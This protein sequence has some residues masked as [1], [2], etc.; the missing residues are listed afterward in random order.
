MAMD[1]TPQDQPVVAASVDTLEARGLV[2]VASYRPELEYLFRHWLV[3]DAAYGSLLRQERRALHRLVGEALES[4]YPDRRGEQAGILAMHFEQAG[5]TERAIEYLVL[6]GRYG[7]QRAAIREAYAAFDRAAALLPPESPDEPD[8]L[9]RRRV[10]IAV[11]RARASWPFRSGAEVKAE[12]EAIEPVAERLGDAEL[13][14]Q[15]HVHLAMVHIELGAR[16]DDPAMARSLERLEQLSADLGDPSLAALPLALAGMSKVFSGPIEEGVRALEVA[17][18]RMERRHDSIGAA[19]SRGWLAIGLA[20]LGEF[21]AAEAAARQ[22]S[23]MAA[24]GDLIAQLDAQISEAMVRSLRGDLDRAAPIAQAC[25]QRSEETGATACAMV[26]AWILGDIYQRQGRFQEAGQALRL[27][28]DMSPGSN[29]GMWGPTITAWQRANPP[30][31]AGAGDEG[32]WE[33]ALAETRRI[34]S[35]VGEASVRWKRGQARAAGGNL[36]GALA[37]LEAAAAIFEAEGARP[38]LA[39]TLRDWGET[40]RA[41]GRRAEGDERLRAALALFEAMG[42][43][44]EAAE[45]RAEL[46]TADGQR[47]EEADQK[48]S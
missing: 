26:S 37:D 12:L 25:V 19:F 36:D 9:R 21:E 3:Q 22:A 15:V 29:P 43:E 42:L 20:S 10:E 47:A 13:L 45:V 11:A 2:R 41:A 4:L 32:A 1:V 8:D 14:A 23:E 40:L 39:R 28:R 30:T 35:Q 6:D 24:G 18:P 31:P 17:I 27:A 48:P 33:E 46:G 38:N 16:S 5:D 34:R 7:L 44:R